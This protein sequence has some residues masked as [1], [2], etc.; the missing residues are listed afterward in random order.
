[1]SAVGKSFIS[2]Q[3]YL[4]LERQAP[5]KS[6]YYH[7]EIFAIAGASKEHNKIVPQL[8]YPSAGI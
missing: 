1:M 6:D 4:D 7:G 2:E 8:F 5:H 3:E